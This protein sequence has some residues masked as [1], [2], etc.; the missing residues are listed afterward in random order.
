MKS[1]PAKKYFDGLL[2][3]KADIIMNELPPNRLTITTDTK[4]NNNIIIVELPPNLILR[5]APQP[6]RL[7]SQES[8]QYILQQQQQ[9]QQVAQATTS[10][11]FSQSRQGGIRFNTVK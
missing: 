7:I 4:T 8:G 9:Q 10:S 5:V 6:S 1:M 11:T 3:G 2:R